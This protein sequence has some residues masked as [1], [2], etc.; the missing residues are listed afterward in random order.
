MHVHVSLRTHFH[1]VAGV[2]LNVAAYASSRR[3]RVPIASTVSH[4]CRAVLRC[5]VVQLREK[6]GIKDHMVNFPVVEIIEIPGYGRAAAVRACEELGIQ[7]QN[8]AEKLAKAKE[9]V[10]LKGF[11][12]GVMLVGSHAGKKVCDAKDA[13]KA[14]MI[15]KGFAAVYYE[16]EKL[17]RYSTAACRGVSRCV[18]FPLSL[19]RRSLAP[20]L[21][22]VGACRRFVASC[23]GG[24]A[25]TPRHVLCLPARLMRCITRSRSSGS[26]RSHHSCVA[27][28][29]ACAIERRGVRR[30]AARPVVPRL[31]R[32]VVARP[33]RSTLAVAALQDVRLADG[34]AVRRRCQVARAVG[35][36]PVV[37]PWHKGAVGQAVRHRVAL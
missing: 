7:S 37:R 2:R 27:A 19:A 32:A 13:V 18:V 24:V 4:T 17:V 28:P 11:Y 20:S 9:E 12:E 29:G 25:H 10:Y 6:F 34:G 26:T 22:C 1:A 21:R 23:C 5:G 33:R 15:A 3:A 35:V 8:D 16:P 14:E 36:Q 30:R 31:R